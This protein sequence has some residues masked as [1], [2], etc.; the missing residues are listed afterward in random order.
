[1]T[2]AL[3][4]YVG[5]LVF[6]LLGLNAERKKEVAA[7]MESIAQTLGKFGPRLRDGALPDELLGYA[8][9][10]QDLAARFSRATSDVLPIA[11]REE[12][13]KKLSAAFNAKDLIA[14]GQAEG[15]DELLVFVSQA[16]GTFRSAAA[17]LRASANKFA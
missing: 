8:A 1:M 17:T 10:T 3:V 13:I 12:H 9:E 5:G 16:A 2:A 7:Y 14:R 11:E 15:R 6:K 4:E